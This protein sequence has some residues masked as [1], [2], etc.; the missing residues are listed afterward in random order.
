MS[1]KF[2]TVQVIYSFY[3][4]KSLSPSSLSVS[5]TIVVT[6]GLQPLNFSPQERD[7]LLVCAEL[8]SGS[9][10]RNVVVGLEAENDTA[11]RKSYSDDTLIGGFY[12]QYKERWSSMANI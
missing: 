12:I 10:E 9:L 1:I 7:T 8:T 2:I 5:L 3:C 11:I 6:I 4:I